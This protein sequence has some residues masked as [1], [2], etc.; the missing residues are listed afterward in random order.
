MDE[1]QIPNNEKQSYYDNEKDIM[2]K[3]QFI[4]IKIIQ[5]LNY[6]NFN[7]QK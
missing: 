3:N 1:F 6:M 5:K 2:K 4:K 7:I